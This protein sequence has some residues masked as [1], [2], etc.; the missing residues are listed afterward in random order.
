MKLKKPSLAVSLT[1]GS[2]LCLV[3]AVIYNGAQIKAR[4]EAP[5]SNHSQQASNT[6]KPVS[7]EV[8]DVQS[9]QYKASITGYGEAKARYA[10]TYATEVSGRVN[11]IMPLF[12]TGEIVKKGEV[13]AQLETVAYQQAVAEA[14]SELAQAKLDLLEE[15]RTGKQARLE[16]KR[17]GLAGEPNSLLV[18][19]EPQLAAQEAVVENAQYNL[20][21]AQQDLKNTTLKAPFDA[22]IVTQE[23]QPGSYVQTGSTIAELYSIDRVEI[24]IPLSAKQWSNLPKVESKQ[25]AN[26]TWLV[27]LHSSDGNNSWKGYV[28]RMQQHLDTTSRQRSLIVAVDLP[29][30]KDISLFPGTFVQVDIEGKALD[31][32][33]KLPASAISQEGYIWFVNK[34]NQLHKAFA[35]KLFEK[36]GDVYV[37]PIKNLTSANIVKRP[38]SSYIPGMLVDPKVEG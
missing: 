18:L 6:V 23:I 16:W 9:S 36:A 1:L 37:Q 14:K 21:K 11:A 38:L 27:S 35:N 5:Q 30:D 31:N 13:L 24:E 2:V 12:E 26:K 7:V 4:N 22:L 33:W 20:A 17:S 19:R 34:E 3:G 15:Q 8:I 29:F 10:I 32:L 25:L 28:I